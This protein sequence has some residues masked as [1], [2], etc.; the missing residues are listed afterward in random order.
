MPPAWPAAASNPAA[1]RT[2]CRD[3]SHASTQRPAPAAAPLPDLAW[4]PLRGLAPLSVAAWRPL[5]VAPAPAAPSPP[6][7]RMPC[8]DRRDVP[9]ARQAPAAAPSPGLVWGSVLAAAPVPLAA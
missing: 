7:E 1:E 3:R 5:L 2:L 8:W 4:G 6:A 9:A